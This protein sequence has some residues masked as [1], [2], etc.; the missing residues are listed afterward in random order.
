LTYIVVKY[1]QSVNRG[2][3]KKLY[4][5]NANNG[6]NE[7]VVSETDMPV[8][9]CSG[10]VMLADSNVSSDRGINLTN[11]TDPNCVENVT[12]T[13]HRF[14]GIEMSMPSPFKASYSCALVQLA[15]L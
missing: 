14:N 11:T 15:R 4:L 12:I 9:N 8:T 3:L 7:S 6:V 10:D 2:N 1:L 5:E 13:E